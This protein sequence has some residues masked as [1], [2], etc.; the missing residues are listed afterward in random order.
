MPVPV[1]CGK[2][3]GVTDRARLSV[4]MAAE[5]DEESRKDECLQKVNLRKV[6]G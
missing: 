2:T 5:R 6:K 3:G 1:C 4:V